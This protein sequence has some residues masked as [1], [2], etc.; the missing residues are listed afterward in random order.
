[1]NVIATL[2]AVETL[3]IILQLAEFLTDWSSL[4][5]VEVMLAVFTKVVYKPS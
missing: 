4:Q 1:M 3:D 5:P 2:S